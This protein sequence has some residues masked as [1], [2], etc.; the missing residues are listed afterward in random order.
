MSCSDCTS[1]LPSWP[2]SSP[3]PSHGPQ[4]PA[5]STRLSSL[6]CL[7]RHVRRFGQSWLN[8]FIFLLLSVMLH[9]SDQR[10]SLFKQSGSN[11]MA[12]YQR[13][14]AVRLREK[15]LNLRNHPKKEL[16]KRSE[17]NP[18]VIYQRLS[19]SS[20]HQ[21]DLPLLSGRQSCHH[22]ARVHNPFARCVF[23]APRFVATK[24]VH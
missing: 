15:R 5:H 7:P 19:E 1:W 8:I 10:V 11:P 3:S 4:P 23:Q 2:S 24:Q 9:H 20:H 22:Y 16:S 12:I 6:A 13:L 17:S 21:K 18:M 14:S